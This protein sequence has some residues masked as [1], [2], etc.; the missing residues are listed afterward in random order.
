M[1]SPHNIRDSFTF[2]SEINRMKIP[3]N[4]VI[5]SFDVISLFTNIPKELVIQGVFSNWEKIKRHTQINL[6]LF[7][8]LVAFCLDT[9]YFMFRAQVYHQQ[10]GTAMGSPLSPILADMVLDKLID[11]VVQKLDYVIYF[12]KKYVDDFFLV[13]PKDKVDY[14]LQVFNTYNEHLQFT[15]EVENENKLPFLDVVVIRGDDQTLSTK[16]YAKPIS[17]GRLVNY[18]S[19]HPL[20]QKMNVI[21]NFIKRVITL[22]PQADAQ[23]LKN[24]VHTNLRNNNYPTSLINRIFYRA[25]SQATTEPTLSPTPNII[26]TDANSMPLHTP[27]HTTTTIT[28][29]ASTTASVAIA[30]T[31]AAIPIAA[32][33]D[34]DQNTCTPTT[35]STKNPTTETFKYVSLPYI[36]Q[37]SQRISRCLQ[38][39]YPTVR[40]ANR[41]VNTVGL[42]HTRVKDR[43]DPMQ[44]HNVIYRIP[45]ND[46]DKVY[47]GMTTNK[48]KKRISG[49]QSNINQ[50]NRLRDQ[51]YTNTDQAMIQQSSKTALTEHCARE[52]HRFAL[53]QT[54]IID[55]TYNRTTLPLLECFHIYN[56][57]GTVNH[58]TDV[59]GLSTIYCGLLRTIAAKQMKKTQT[60][61]PSPQH[62]S[63]SNPDN[64][65]P[66]DDQQQQIQTPSHTHR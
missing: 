32:V 25:L 60:N 18:F 7:Q 16:W 35:P 64:Q 52:D 38:Q 5:V 21:T 61:P 42:L 22:S 10:F 58:R 48:L 6:D 54:K 33:L 29:A 2:A 8:E 45:C 57:S 51:G 40:I 9:S 23:M 17:S 39:D 26:S 20:P 15:V 34:P 65:Q 14:T 46:C 4:H 1:C 3:E 13:L 24:I 27:A 30:T 12:L 56:T 37:L 11:T 41:K 66:T 36:P 31:N 19:Y 62:P 49:H 44:Q 47:I 53:Q 50:L 43:I 63:T 28:E 55:R 59:E